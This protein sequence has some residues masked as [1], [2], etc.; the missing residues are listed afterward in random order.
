MEEVKTPKSLKERFV[1]WL[2]NDSNGSDPFSIFVKMPFLI[3]FALLLIGKT[4]VDLV[5]R[6][7]A[8]AKISF[9][10]VFLATILLLANS[11]FSYDAAIKLGF[12]TSG[13][14]AFLA[15]YL[16]VKAV[17]RF[18]NQDAEQENVDSNSILFDFLTRFEIKTQIIESVI[19][20]IALLAIGI[21][22]SFYNIFLGLPIAICGLSIW[23]NLIIKYIFYTNK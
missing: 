1:L 7:K 2:F 8:V 20:P 18:Q 4:I 22:L 19:E 3:V 11:W 23:Y 16:I 13:F 6:K 17:I 15:V 21:Y 5:L 12:F 14:Y 9:F 10:N